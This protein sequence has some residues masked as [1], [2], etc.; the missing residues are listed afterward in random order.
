M[1]HPGTMPEHG[2]VD[3]PAP[4][5]HPPSST[6]PSGQGAG[7]GTGHVQVPSAHSAAAPA[8]GIWR[9]SA[10]NT[11]V[12]LIGCTIGDVGVV[13]ASWL[14]FPH[15]SA[16][17]IMVLAIVAGLATSLSLESLW[18]MRDGTPARQALPMAMS[19][20]FASMVAMEVA[21]NLVDLGLTG[22]NRAHLSI[23]GY[24]G[25]LALGEIAGFLVPW[26]YNAWRLSQGRACHH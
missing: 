18:L 10:H 21:M 15:L 22:G 24:L 17:V 5:C 19:M 13:A 23:A 16:A 6:A 26:P 1:N 12:C 4:C 2:H 11:L 3:A 9:R 25:I 8:S 20:S 14:W 7:H